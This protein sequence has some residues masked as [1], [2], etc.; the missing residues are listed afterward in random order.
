MRYTI[1]DFQAC[2]EKV[3]LPSPIKTVWKAWGRGPGGARGLGSWEGGFLCTLQDGSD[4]Y[5]VGSCD[6]TGW[7]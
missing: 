6:Y 7:G 5:I 1:A 2:I 3:N 4:V